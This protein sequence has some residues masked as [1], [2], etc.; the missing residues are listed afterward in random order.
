MKPSQLQGRS[1]VRS[2][3]TQRLIRFT[4]AGAPKSQQRRINSDYTWRPQE[5]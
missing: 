2:S 3:R 5:I 4:E 1:E